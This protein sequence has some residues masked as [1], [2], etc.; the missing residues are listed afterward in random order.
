M[1]IGVYS[2]KA[3]AILGTSVWETPSGRI[4]TCTVTT[5]APESIAWDD[6]VVHGPVKRLIRTTPAP[7]R[8]RRRQAPEPVPAPRHRGLLSRLFH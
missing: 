4:V 7:D 5:D 3:A 8:A 2:A 6:K 1:K